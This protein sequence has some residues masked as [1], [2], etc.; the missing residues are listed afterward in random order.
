MSI[1]KINHNWLLLLTLPWILIGAGV[2]AWHISTSKAPMTANNTQEKPIIQTEQS[3]N[4][5]AQPSDN[6]TIQQSTNE[7]IQ[8]SNTVT[9]LFGGDLMFDRYIRQVAMKQGNDFVF[10]PSLRERMRSADAVIANL[11]GPITSHA[12]KS[13]GSVIGSRENYYFTF[14]PSWAK[15]LKDNNISTVNI[16]NNHILNFGEAGLSETERN[17]TAAGVHFFGSPRESSRDEALRDE[18]FRGSP[19]DEVL[20][21]SPRDE[22]LQGSPRDEVFRGS[23]DAQHRATILNI[24][25]LKIGLV[26]ENQFTTDS[27]TKALED[28]RTLRSQVDVLIAY[29]HWGKEYLPATDDEKRRAHALIEAGADAVIGSHPHV[30]QEKEVYRGKTI[31]YS[32]GNFVFD[33]YEQPETTKGLLVSLTIDPTTKALHFEDIPVTLQRSGQTTLSV[34]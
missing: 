33:Q 2:L 20:Q 31:Y 12:S 22:V 14:D 16:G 17:L 23:L 27:E 10:A 30:V 7:T 18:V 13:V 6:T 8:P 24:K 29:T 4:T 19:R 11:E 28:V 9:L 3:P 32:L 15:T 34:K 5:T 26:N 25:G 21:G 1:Q